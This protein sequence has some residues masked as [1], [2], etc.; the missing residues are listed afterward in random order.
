MAEIKWQK[1]AEGELYRILVKGFLEFGE[2]M[3][4]KFSE[5]VAFINQ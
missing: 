3:A 5:R 2:A 1:R 4:N